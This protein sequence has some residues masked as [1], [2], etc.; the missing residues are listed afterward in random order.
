MRHAWAALALV[1]LV[2]TANAEDFEVFYDETFEDDRV[3]L[4]P[5]ADGF[6]DPF[7]IEITEEVTI[8]TPY[9]SPTGVF[10]RVDV[11]GLATNQG[12][13]DLFELKLDGD[14][15]LSTTNLTSDTLHPPPP[16][17]YFSPTKQFQVFFGFGVI[18]LGGPHKLELKVT[19]H[20]QGGG[21]KLTVRLSGSANN[22]GFFGALDPSVKIM[23]ADELLQLTQVRGAEDLGWTEDEFGPYISDEPHHASVDE[24]GVVVTY[25]E[26]LNSEVLITSEHTLVPGASTPKIASCRIL[27]GWRIHNYMG[28]NVLVRQLT[29]DPLVPGQTVRFEAVTPY[30]GT[31][32]E[33]YN[34]DTGQLIEQTLGPVV[35]IPV[36]ESFRLGVYVYGSGA[37]NIFSDDFL[38][39]VFGSY[40][41]FVD[42]PP[43]TEESIRLEDDESNQ[44]E[45]DNNGP[46][47]VILHNGEQRFTRVD[48]AIPGRT[49]MVDFVLAR[50]HRS[51]V[52]LRGSSLG[53]SWGLL[54]FDERVFE[55]SNGDLNWHDGGGRIDHWRSLGDGAYEAP[56]GEFSTLRK[57]PDGTYVRVFRA[58]RG[59]PW[60]MRH[61]YRADGRLER[62][63][64]P[65]GNCLIVERDGTG[66]INRVFDSFYRPITFEWEG[67]LL[68]RVRDFQD[69]VVQ[70]TYDEF[71]NVIEVRTPV[72]TG[73]STANDF[74]AG[75][76]ESY[77]YLHGS[78]PQLKHNLVSVT[79][80]QE[81]ADGGAPYLTWQY[82][83]DPED[84]STFDR[85][86]VQD[87]GGINASGVSAGGRTLFTYEFVNQGT[88]AGSS[89][90]A[91][92]K[93]VVVDPNGNVS[94]HY[95][96]EFSETI[97]V[98]RLT[99][100][101][102]VTDPPAYEEVREFNA[103]GMRV[104]TVF[105]E[106]NELVLVYPTS[107][108]RAALED[109]V[110]VRMK[111]GPRGGGPDKV[112][113]FT[114][115]PL[116]RLP[117][118][119][120]DPRGTTS[121]Y[122]P[123]LGTASEARYTARAYVDYMEGAGT[124]PLAEEFG[125]DL[126]SVQRGLGDLNGDGRTDQT[127]GRVVRSV[128]PSVLL[129]E[130]SLEAQ[131]LAGTA[132]AIVTETRWNDHGQLL[133]VIDPEGNI[134]TCGYFP[135]NDPSASG[136]VTPDVPSDPSGYLASVTRDA[137]VSPRRTSSVA[138]TA[139]KTSFRRNRVG[140]VVA[141]TNPRGVTTSFEVNALNEV[142]SI[143]RG[144][145]V[146]EAVASSQLLGTEPARQY[147][148]RLIY[149]GNGR[150]V[151]TEIQDRD[152]TSDVLGGFSEQAV[153][154][155]ILDQPVEVTVEVDA[156]TRLTSLMRYDLNQN[157]ILAQSASG[158]KTRFEWDERDLPMAVLRGAD[159]P[160]Q[161]RVSFAV[162]GNGNRVTMI[163]AEDHDGDG[164]G[165]SSRFRFDGFD[166]LVEVVDALGNKT[167]LT[168][169]PAGNQVR[170]QSF[171]AGPDPQV[172]LAEAR[173]HHDELGRTFRVDRALFMAAGVVTTRPVTLHDQD[174]DGWVT[175][176]AEQDAL[177]RVVAVIEDDLQVS[178]SR[179]DGAS[180][181][182]EV[183]DA[184]GNKRTTVFDRNGN[185]TRVTS[186]ERSPEALVPDEQFTTTYV[187]DQLDRL[188]RATDNIGQTARF[189]YDSR[190]NLVLRSDAVGALTIDPLG[191]FPG[192]I[193]DPGNTSS[194]VYDGLSRQLQV[195]HDLR[196]GGQGGAPLD[197]TNAA[198]PDG[199]VALTYVWDAGSRLSAMVDDKGQTT[200]FG[201]DALDRKIRHTF[202]DQSAWQYVW[203]RDG[204]LRQ[205]TDPNGTVA[206]RT[207]DA[208]NRLSAVQIQRAT[209]V[210]GTTAETYAWDGLS[211]L[212][213]AT[214]D[215]GGGAGATS[216]VERAW[217]SLS[218]VVE[219]RQD[220]RVVSSTWS[221]DGKRTGLMY[222]GGRALT[223]AH[224]AID[225]LKTIGEAGTPTIA[226][227]SWIG[228]GLRPL[229]RVHGNQ[230]VMSMVAAGQDVGYDGVQR[231]V[232]LRHLL[233]GG[234]AA[235]LDREHGYDRA[236]N[237]TFERR[238]DDQG[239]T[240][241][242]TYDSL[243][244]VVAS[245]YDQG[246]AS[247]AQQRELLA[248]AY[249]YDGVGNRVQAQETRVVPGTGPSMALHANETVELDH[250]ALVQGNVAAL[251][252]QHNTVDV[253][254]HARLTGNATGPEVRL[255]HHAQIEGGASTNLLSVHPTAT[256]G[257]VV[258]P[259]SS[260]GAVPGLAPI[261]P[262]ST[263][264]N[265]GPNQTVTL[266]PGSY[267][268]VSLQHHARLILTAG[269]YTVGALQVGP[270]GVIEVRGPVLIRAATNLEFDHH[271]QV[272]LSPGV[273]HADVRWETLDT[274]LH[275]GPDCVFAGTVLAPAAEVEVEHHTQLTGWI[276][277]KRVRVGP[278][279]VVVAPGGNG[280][281][282]PVTTT[283]GYIA[284]SVN[285]Y[286]S[287]GGVTRAHD[288]NGNLR[289]DGT[290]L[291]A[292]DYR[293]R[294]VGVAR[295]SDGAAIAAYRYDALGRR[296]EKTLY[297]QAS[298]GA[299]ERLTRF[300]WS[301]WTLLE[302][303][304]AAGV[305]ECTY[306]GGV[307]IDEH[308]QWSRTASHPLGAGT[309]YLHQDARGDVVAAT[310]V[311]GAVVERTRFDDFGRA[312][313]TSA[314]GSALGFQGRYLDRETGLY[315]FRHRVYDPATGR[316][317]QRDPVWDPLNAGSQHAFV[318][319]S[320]VSRRDPR[321]LMDEE[322]R[323]A[324]N[325]FMR[326]KSL[327]KATEFAALAARNPGSLPAEVQRFADGLKDLIGKQKDLARAQASVEAFS[328]TVPMKGDLVSIAANADDLARIERLG[329]E[330]ARQA[331]VAQEE[332]ARAGVQA[333]T[334][335]LGVATR[336]LS[337]TN[338]LLAEG[339]AR[340]AGGEVGQAFGQVV[341]KT[342]RGKWYIL[343]PVLLIGA[344]GAARP[345]DAI[346]LL[347]PST[348]DA[349]FERGER[350]LEYAPE[351][352]WDAIRIA[353]AGLA[354]EPGED[355]M[356]Y[357]TGVKQA[358]FGAGFKNLFFGTWGQKG[359]GA[360]EFMGA[361]IQWRQRLDRQ[362][363]QPCS[364]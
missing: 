260:P 9:R 263:Q 38:T 169:D 360:A 358:D 108:Q 6:G 3:V 329:G 133:A 332:A 213:R 25:R 247:G 33:W 61:V 10:V 270:H 295:K 266:A 353:T 86:I 291:L 215:N 278:H 18:W 87:H 273:T 2:G 313:H 105:P 107:G 252:P 73:T 309:F 138:P 110:Q 346:S 57:R 292:Y 98:R 267:S 199:K 136:T 254:P 271:A 359:A 268:S 228:P 46:C 1:G 341:Q 141:V 198:N 163:D 239:L 314:I 316:F 97:K 205:T 301:S 311:G 334:E 307:S 84:S 289:D 195:V 194:Y 139:L 302:E 184:L 354:T 356:D 101:L 259:Y 142:V 323:R 39:A 304:G 183:E 179:Y 43:P 187:W 330:A 229:A 225:R 182:F 130:G 269:T 318:G 28:E 170:T 294:L 298:P 178:R 201:Y 76:N 117:V 277:A 20:R 361:A 305:T 233:P 7:N 216:V 12:V 319:N 53:P 112:W 274:S 256:L 190:D 37:I 144:A 355:L 351:A 58:E 171:A 238:L 326:T 55:Q 75:R 124:V 96:N 364:R 172:L 243:Y 157:P 102:R 165:D 90:T 14:I 85:V 51:R 71:T 32:Y 186:L 114:Y 24:N 27:I 287:V 320:P 48:M 176:F 246:G 230:T 149:D 89:T 125:I 31:R 219:E 150:V 265:A 210:G 286:T 115:D 299:V 181:L 204:N 340:A 137:E 26:G 212:I 19:G 257:G 91:R 174:A 214:D 119:V 29:P 72:V 145:D 153:T 344:A 231:L 175:S 297:S 147:L 202:A 65:S 218:R 315:E 40:T 118:A 249:R 250:H 50:R 328:I 347:M 56:R 300:F 191:L 35:D 177:S 288:A 262:G 232:R 253:N 222:P 5:G 306:V 251:G 234:A 324:W 193:N 36:S 121:G 146:G 349:A 206:T 4:P 95:S 223:F 242:Y 241:G 196:V 49:P 74:P 293:N 143:T 192:Q 362:S 322:L 93:A 45:T 113:R 203:D 220:G 339:A 16:W 148:T 79:R 357:T 160:E 236:S 258:V 123:P 106:G 167:V 8:P 168:W 208:L 248:S 337:K 92:V 151:R 180:R 111:P 70:F 88:P 264:V 245:V 285:E 135:G 104:R 342:A 303:Q 325:D 352:G 296:V 116:Y 162:D 317:L 99:R 158:A 283:I 22:T 94:E 363:A 59:S 235:F 227:Y 62:I 100:G 30:A 13:L 34:F 200:S 209:G 77:A 255:Q 189:A 335:E 127:Q 69:R 161:A 284:N 327:E 21:P 240:D 207:F 129:R 166:Q 120:V 128:A 152:G 312:D 221:G 155:D 279:A 63:E 197:L 272:V 109:P 15:L 226:T 338:R 154:Y 66:R 280:S 282:Q 188:V 343:V 276:Q 185:P 350:G 321:G 47:S 331:A 67:G 103:H 132:Q 244:R 126:S 41:V 44:G 336:Q 217:D 131:R 78:N 81:V 156:T 333:A 159:E 348:Y 310:D 122:V 52:D 80:P 237:R 140:M 60:G 164:S 281:S 345:E 211:R 308:V 11:G 82:G 54:T 134:T 42:A 290:R 83:T 224:D 17:R 68:R 173:S 275:I 64:D 261:A 23:G